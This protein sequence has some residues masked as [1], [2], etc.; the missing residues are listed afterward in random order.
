MICNI[1]PRRCSADRQKQLGFCSSPENFKLARAALHYWEEPCI[2]ATQ[3]SGTV[4]FSGCNLRCVYCQNF[5]ISH[6][7]KGI[8]I[9]GDKLIE[10]FED[11]IAQGANN[12]NLVNPTHYTRQLA[13]VLSKWKSP[14]PVVYNTSGYDS[15]EGLKL[16][17]GLVDIYLTDFKYIRPEKALRYSRAQDYPLVVRR[18]L[19]EMK[20]QQGE[21]V[22]D[23]RGLMRKG[24]IIRHLILPSNTNSAIEI[25]DY[26][27][28][29]YNQPY[30]SLMAQYTPC[31][32]LC[33]YKEIDR[34]LTRREYEKVINYAL[35]LDNPNIFVQDLTSSSKKYIPEFDFTGIL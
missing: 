7:N 32:D 15:V 33:D 6:N 16:L 1:C 14:V 31:T 11:L 10:I 20:R 24:V 8:E 19:D 27:N 13:A 17:D 3:G 21:D 4:F 28:D 23:D 26:L 25:L 9:D 18:A 5:E 2:S 12:I 29:T 30:I 22:F 34:T 35:S